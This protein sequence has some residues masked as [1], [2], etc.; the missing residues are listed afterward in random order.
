MT[1]LV[2]WHD[3]EQQSVTYVFE[4]NWDWAELYEAF[5]QVRGVERSAGHRVDVILKMRTDAAPHL[6]FCNGHY[7]TNNAFVH[8]LIQQ[9]LR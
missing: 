6:E 4:G 5:K 8:A 1:V 7:V 3:S 2:D 9:H